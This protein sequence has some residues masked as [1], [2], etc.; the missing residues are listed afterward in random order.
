[1]WSVSRGGGD[2]PPVV[3]VPSSVLLLGLSGWAHGWKDLPGQGE[4]PY[5]IQQDLPSPL[6]PAMS[7]EARRRGEHG[8]PHPSQTLG[9]ETPS[10][11]SQLSRAVCVFRI[12][13]CFPLSELGSP[14]LPTSISPCHGW[15][16]I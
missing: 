7:Q 1:M 6:S 5:P 15:G 2:V 9:D 16:V 14:V 8:I 13:D 3:P 12:S 4:S 11:N 10:V